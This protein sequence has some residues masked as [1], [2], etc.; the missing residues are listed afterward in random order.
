MVFTELRPNC[1]CARDASPVVVELE[2]ADRA[3]FLAERRAP[4]K[5]DV[6][7][8]LEFNRAVDAEVGPRTARQ[9]ALERDVDR[10]R[11]VHARPGRCESPCRG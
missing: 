2:E 7:Q 1:T 10:D 4:D 5:Q 6:I 8:A 9:L 3:L 11:A